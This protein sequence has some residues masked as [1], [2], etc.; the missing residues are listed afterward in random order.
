MVRL[1]YSGRTDR[2]MAVEGLREVLRVAKWGQRPVVWIDD[3]YRLLP[4][5]RSHIDPILAKVRGPVTHAQKAYQYKTEN[6]NEYVRTIYDVS[7]VVLEE[8]L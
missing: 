8:V 3:D 6:T 1:S 5:S 2:G 7:G 4:G